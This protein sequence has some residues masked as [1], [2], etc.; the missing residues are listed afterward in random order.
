MLFRSPR[1]QAA[2]GRSSL[3]HTPL[4]VNKRLTKVQGSLWRVASE[5][6]GHRA[7]RAQPQGIH[8]PQVGGHQARRCPVWLR[9]EVV[10][11]RRR[12][13]VAFITQAGSQG[14]VCV[15]LLLL[16]LLSKQSL[17]L[18][19]G[20]GR[21]MEIQ[22]PKEM[23]W[24]RLRLCPDVAVLPSGPALLCPAPDAKLPIV[25]PMTTATIPRIPKSPL[26]SACP[27]APRPATTAAAGKAACTPT[28]ALVYYSGPGLIPSKNAV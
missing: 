7:G 15:W 24:H 14:Y 2:P 10:R 11:G 1:S 5:R 20:R 4:R 8:P 13:F 3:R 21:G 17:W 26:M 16:L 23:P 12:V 19:Q 22:T 25:W 27:H 6:P 9:L 18:F 28:F